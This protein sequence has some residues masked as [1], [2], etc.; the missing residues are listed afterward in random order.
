MRHGLYRLH[1]AIRIVSHEPVQRSFSE[2]L[3]LVN[4]SESLDWYPPSVET[5]LFLEWHRCWKEVHS[6]NPY[7][8][9][10][11]TYTSPKAL[12]LEDANAHAFVSNCH[13]LLFLHYFGFPQYFF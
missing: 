7:C 2:F 1:I 5:D 11:P 13:L 10:R 8:M 4:L 9:H 6:V 12:T 3:G